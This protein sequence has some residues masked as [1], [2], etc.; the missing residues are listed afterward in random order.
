MALPGSFEHSGT[1]LLE[2]QLPFA[3]RLAR[4]CDSADAGCVSVAWKCLTAAFPWLFVWACLP[5]TDSY[6]FKGHPPAQ[7]AHQII[8]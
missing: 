5:G 2:S 3:M 7:N 4:Y 6:E 1:L 8:S